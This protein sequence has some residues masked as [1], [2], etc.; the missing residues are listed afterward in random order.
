MPKRP[1]RRRLPVSRPDSQGMSANRRGGVR[2]SK[3]RVV[4]LLGSAAGSCVG[5]G[6]VGPG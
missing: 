3:Q 4:R 2:R 1:R 5:L 6:S